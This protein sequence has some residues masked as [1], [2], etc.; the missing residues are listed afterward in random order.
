[1]IL[2]DLEVHTGEEPNSLEFSVTNGIFL[3]QLQSKKLQGYILDQLAAE[4]STRYTITVSLRHTSRAKAPAPEPEPV[5]N[6]YETTFAKEPTQTTTQTSK[7]QQEEK[8]TT[9]E[10]EDTIFYK[11]YRA[12]PKEM[13]EGALPVLPG[14]I[15]PPQKQ[16]EDWAEVENMFELE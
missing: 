3:A 14:P 5:E 15:E 1:M 8:L 9:K 4:T 11:V 10:S 2:P 6:P 16:E 13:E 12:L 7:T